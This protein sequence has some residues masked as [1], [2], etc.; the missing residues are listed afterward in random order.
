MK[1]S[2]PGGPFIDALGKPLLGEDLTDTDEYDPTLFTEDDANLTTYIA[3]GRNRMD[4]TS[5]F[6]ITDFIKF[7]SF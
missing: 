6:Y 2:S 4:E 1:S 7:Q 5:Y 3:F